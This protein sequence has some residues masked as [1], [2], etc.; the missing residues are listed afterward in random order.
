MAPLKKD[1]LAF[2]DWQNQ[3]NIMGNQF[4]SVFTKEDTSNLPDLGPSNTQSAPPINVDPKGIQKLLKDSKPHKATGPDCIPARLLKSAA[5]ELAPGLA[6]LF[7]ISVDNGKIP[8]DWKTALVTPVFKKGNRSDPGNYRPI[9]LTSIA[10]MILEHVI[11]SCIINHFERHNILTDC[12]HGFRK[13][14]SCET[15][16]IMTVDDLARGLIEKQQVDAVLLDFSKAFD[17]VPHQQLLLKLEHYGVRG[18]LLKW[19]E[20]FLSA[21]TQEVVIDGTK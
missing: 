4:S 7:Q 13:G 18:N 12:Q 8:L 21:R 2:C 16:L 10:C 3:A 1:G 9:S 14:R 15:Q 19:V 6:H 20:D 17:K 5:D 11:H